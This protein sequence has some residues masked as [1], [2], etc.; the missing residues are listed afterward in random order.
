MK[1]LLQ[2]LLEN[3]KYTSPIYRPLVESIF[4]YLQASMKIFLP[5]IM[6][7]FAVHGMA[8]STSA[9]MGAGAAGMGYA[10]ATLTDKWAFFNNIAGL[11]RVKD[12]SL[13]TSYEVRPSLPGGN[14]MCAVFTTPFSFGAPA[15]GVFRFGDDVYSEQI[16]SVGFANQIGNT[17]LG[18]KFSYIQYRAEGFGTHAAI[19]LN[20]GGITQLTPKISIG[21]WIQN[22]NQ[23]KIN[24]ADKEKAPVKLLAA[25]SFS[26]SE[27]FTVVTE[28]EKD[29]LYDPLWKTGME[30][31][32]HKKFLVRA[33]FNVHPNAVFLGVGFHGSRI[34]ID[35]ALQSLTLFSASHQASASYRFS[36]LD[37]K[38]K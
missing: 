14:R 33:G 27:K 26:P 30:Y 18:A 12:R 29:V 8:Q 17:S 4:T 10:S 24:F 2:S 15:V 32:I 3:P 25:L 7:L 1:V 31:T 13:A 11:A 21:A 6:L 36:T 38:E 20:V 5:S 35:Y 34:D 19:G 37:A 16:I 9:L 22:I 28:I 23:P